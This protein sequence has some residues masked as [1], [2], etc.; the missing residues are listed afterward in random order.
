MDQEDEENQQEPSNPLP[1]PH[2]HPN[3]EEDTH[4]GASAS[5][6]AYDETEDEGEEWPVEAIIEH[7]HDGTTTQYLVKW[8]GDDDSH[9]WLPEDALDSAKE[10][11]AAYHGR[12]EGVGKGRGKEKGKGKG[13]EQVQGAW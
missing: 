1:K 7:Y 12:I 13:K 6:E 3:E 5:Q 8:E 9:D 4:P 2:P 11:I 10:L